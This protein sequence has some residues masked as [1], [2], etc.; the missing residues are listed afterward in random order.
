MKMRTLAAVLAALTMTAGAASAQDMT[1]DKGKLSYVFGYQLGGQ[2]AQVQDSGEQIDINSAVKGIQDAYAKKDPAL[3][4]AQAKPVMEAFQRRQEAR[5]Q[6]AKAEYDKA[7]AANLTKSN[8]FLAANKAKP[9]VKAL[10][11]GVQYRVV[12]AGTGA[13]PALGSTISVAFAG[14][15]FMGQ[16]PPEGAK[17]EQAPAMKLSEVQVEGLREAITQMP[18]GS[19]WEITLPPSKAFGADPR[20]G[21]P[22]NAAVQFDVKLNSV[23]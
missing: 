22:P 9:G 20:T 5:A 21:M 1:T 2:L 11:S 15:F 18:A 4:E 6:Q 10:P 12:T 17:L 14:P 23:K 19:Q 8:Q 13:R 3:A 16:R 7:A